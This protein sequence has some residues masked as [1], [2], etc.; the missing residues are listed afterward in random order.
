MTDD[1]LKE[2]SRAAKKSNGVPRG[3]EAGVTYCVLDEAAARQ[4]WVTGSVVAKLLT[5]RSAE[6]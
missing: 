1:I 6:A 2:A 4:R 3:H 5:Q